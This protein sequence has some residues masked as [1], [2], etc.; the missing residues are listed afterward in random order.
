[1]CMNGKRENPLIRKK[2]SGRF[3]ILT[4]NTK[5]NCTPA[6]FLNLENFGN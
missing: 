5:K 6:D 3:F 2:W 1:M 4:A